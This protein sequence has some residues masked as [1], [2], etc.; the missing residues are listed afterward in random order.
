MLFVFFHELRFY[1]YARSLYDR[2]M[3]C[4]VYFAAYCP[5]VAENEYMYI[6]YSDPSSKAFGPRQQGSKLTFSCAEG[7][8][9][10]GS[11]ERECVNGAWTGSPQ[12]CQR[13]VSFVTF[14]I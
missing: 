11:A 4:C 13:G 3:C 8:V 7:Y 9:K 10:V 1:P 5:A 14:C 6:S 2:N 12:S